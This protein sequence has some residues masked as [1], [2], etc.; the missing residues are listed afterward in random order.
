MADWHEAYPRLHEAL[1]PEYRVLP[2]AQVETVVQGVFGEGVSLADAESFFGDLGNTLSRAATVVAP[3]VQRALPGVMSGAMS[4]AALGPWGALGGA[5]IGG[6]SSA[7]SGGGGGGGAR[8]PAGGRPGAPGR[9]R[10]PM[11]LPIP[12]VTPAAAPGSAP[13][14]AVGQLLGVLGSPTVQQAL[15]SMLMGSAGARSVPG[16]G[17]AQL[18]VAA[19]TNLLGMLASRA[20]AEWEELVPSPEAEA[21]GEGLDFAAPEARAEWVMSQLAPIEVVESD[22]GESFDGESSDEAWVDELYDE[23]E[24]EMAGE[25][26]GED[27]GESSD[28]GYDESLD[29]A[30]YESAES[31]SW[32]LT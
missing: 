25:S 29:E 17:G 24:A 3:V 7:L 23:L 19:I 13:T 5:L 27:Y 10:A 4:G 16:A 15:S 12:G 31:E 18:P 26:D 21:L 20:S 32:S 6:V 30:D 8:P 14:A 2:E 22:V 11:R 28:E 9:P 1:A